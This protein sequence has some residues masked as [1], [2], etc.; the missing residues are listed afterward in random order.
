MRTLRGIAIN[1]HKLLLNAY[2]D[3]YRQTL[4]EHI[5]PKLY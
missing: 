3:R 1:I 5:E 4:A 2:N